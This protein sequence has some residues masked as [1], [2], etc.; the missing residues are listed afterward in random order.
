MKDRQPIPR[1]GAIPVRGWLFCYLGSKVLTVKRF[2][3]SRSACRIIG[4][5]S[6]RSGKHRPELNLRADRTN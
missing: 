3:C 2:S 6:C 4:Q 1:P 5:T